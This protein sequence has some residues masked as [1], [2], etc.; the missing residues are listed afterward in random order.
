MV[1]PLTSQDLAKM[2]DEFMNITVHFEGKDRPMEFPLNLDD[3]ALFSLILQE[4]A[5]MDQH[6]Q[7]TQPEDGP[8]SSQYSLFSVS[9]SHHTTLEVSSI[10][11]RNPLTV[12]VIREVLLNDGMLL[13]ARKGTSSQ[14]ADADLLTNGGMKLTVDVTPSCSVS[15]YIHI[16]LEL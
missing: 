9:G 16:Y 8:L 11:S 3:A 15:V 6:H 2:E 4:V 1:S 14:N 7:P 10:S 5:D 13:A 12:E